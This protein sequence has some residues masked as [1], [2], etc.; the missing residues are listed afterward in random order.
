VPGMPVVITDAGPT[1][2]QQPA[3]PLPASIVCHCHLII[4]AWRS[5]RRT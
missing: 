3:E 1:H 5:M 4:A 2:L